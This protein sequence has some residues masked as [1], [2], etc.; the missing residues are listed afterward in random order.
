MSRASGRGGVLRAPRGPVDLDRHPAGCG[1]RFD[2]FERSVPA[3]IREQPRA[4]AD[5]HGIGEQDD[6]VDQLVVEEPADQLA[7][8]VHLQLTRRLGF[9]LADRG[10]D[11]TGEDGRF[12]PARFGERGRCH[13]LRLR[14]ECR[15]DRAVTWIWP[16]SPGAGEDLVGPPAK[17]ERVGALVHLTEERV[18]LVDEKRRGPSAPLESAPAVLVR[19]AE[20][21]HHSIDG[22]VR[23]GR[24]F[25]G[26]SSLLAEF[27]VGWLVDAVTTALLW[28]Y[29]RMVS[30]A[31]TASI[32]LTAWRCPSC[33][34]MARICS[35]ASVL[36]NTFS[37]DMRVRPWATSSMP[38]R[39]VLIGTS[40][41]S[42]PSA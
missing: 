5:N 4:L 40:V 20:S 34:P 17:Q 18:G 2:Q 31:R 22:D 6:L 28:I 35:M 37:I 41:V 26:R 1:P 9:Q 13:V 29:R 10:R 32:W 8:A 39:I 33:V 21:L 42:V 19:P 27:V 23:D 16:H 38:T 11:V 15:P 36:G 7:A 3:G 25:H 30:S 14:V 12:R 24:Q